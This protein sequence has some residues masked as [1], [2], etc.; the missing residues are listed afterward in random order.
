M[1]S[2]FEEGDI[3]KIVN[4]HQ[5]EGS[6]GVIYGVIFKKHQ[7][8]RYKVLIVAKR[9]KRCYS[10]AKYEEFFSGNL[11]KEHDRDTIGKVGKCVALARH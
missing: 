11:E 2:K 9:N 3:V 10:K 6:Y 1:E 8:H 5:Y 7:Y 4:H